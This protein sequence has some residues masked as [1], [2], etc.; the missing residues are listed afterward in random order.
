MRIRRQA[1]REA[2]NLEREHLLAR[3]RFSRRPFSAT[4]SES[5]RSF[6]A[7]RDWGFPQGR[8]STLRMGA[9]ALLHGAFVLAK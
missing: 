1:A 8:V 4:Y 9:T 3:D 2:E 6:L 7:W 5:I